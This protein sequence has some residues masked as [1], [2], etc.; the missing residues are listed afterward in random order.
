MKRA[1]DEA[2]LFYRIDEVS[3]IA[4]LERRVIEKW[5]REFPF[6]HAGQTGSGQKIF[7]R[8][9][10]DIILRLKELL[11]QEGLTLAGAKRKI[12]TEFEGRSS[13]PLHPDR[14]KKTLVEVR[15][16]LQDLA[17]LLGKKSRK[18]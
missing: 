12:E 6:L 15:D 13:E 4:N 18:L 9:D 17:S 5:E 7:R 3:R 8:R 1:K 11:V 16:N 14:L 10:L 2:K